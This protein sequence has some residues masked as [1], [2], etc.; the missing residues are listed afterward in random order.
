MCTAQIFIS[1]RGASISAAFSSENE[2]IEDVDPLCVSVSASTASTATL[3]KF[4]M[5]SH[6]YSWCLLPSV[7]PLDSPLSKS[8]EAYRATLTGLDEAELDADLHSIPDMAGMA[9]VLR[10]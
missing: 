7:E 10:G 3:I 6:V 4:P 9:E 2:P 5:L 8:A 1:S